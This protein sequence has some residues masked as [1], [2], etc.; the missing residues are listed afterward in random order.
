MALGALLVFVLNQGRIIALWHA[1]VSDR[2]LFG[3][4]HGTVL[5]LALIAACLVFFLY[6]LGRHD[7]RPA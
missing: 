2:A 5:P 1:F 4:L 6:F 7:P 3:L